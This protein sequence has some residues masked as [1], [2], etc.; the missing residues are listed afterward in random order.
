MQNSILQ[1]LGLLY[2]E[3][4]LLKEN[5]YIV[6]NS[7]YKNMDQILNILDDNLIFIIHII[8]SFNYIKI[9]DFIQSNPIYNL[10][11]IYETIYPE[12]NI[13][14]LLILDKINN[15]NIN[16]VFYRFDP[17]IEFNEYGQEI[18]PEHHELFYGHHSIIRNFRKIN[19][20]KPIEPTF[21]KL[22]PLRC[23]SEIEVIKNNFI[24]LKNI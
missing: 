11:I 10:P 12:I 1:K 15:E 13:D 23:I 5:N 20:T 22:D 19:D 3:I 16:N 6:E 17:I 21:L 24:H 9:I 14:L 18:I 4:K 2:L 8:L 7:K